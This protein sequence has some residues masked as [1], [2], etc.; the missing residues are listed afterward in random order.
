M[1]V[2]AAHTGSQPDTVVIELGHAVVANATM[3]AP[4]WSED[5]AGLA[6][7]QFLQTGTLSHW[8]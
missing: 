2:S 3:A 1:V 6:K 7:L 8:I 4:W 5:V